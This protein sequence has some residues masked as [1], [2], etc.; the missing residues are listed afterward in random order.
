VRAEDEQQVLLQALHQL[1]VE[2]GYLEGEEVPGA[3]S[4]LGGDEGPMAGILESEDEQL[5]NKIRRGLAKVAAAALD[6]G[7][8]GAANENAVGAA[9]DG[10]ELVMRGELIRGNVTRLP[11]LI[12]SFVFLVT[13]PV[14]DQDKALEISERCARLLGNDSS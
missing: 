5:V 12:P 11:A 8:P 4:P 14:V 1:Y 3:I 2:L 6:G 7:E 10:A 13:L 9:L